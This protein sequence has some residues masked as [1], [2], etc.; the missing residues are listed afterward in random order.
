MSNV[1]VKVVRNM[2]PPTGGGANR[3]GVWGEGD[4]GFVI[5]DFILGDGY[6]S[7]VGGPRV[8]PRANQ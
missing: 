7:G 1:E 2:T 3:G 4:F 8:K 5:L 6:I